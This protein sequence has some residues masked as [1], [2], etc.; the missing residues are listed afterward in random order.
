MKLIMSDISVGI[1]KRNIQ[2]YIYI[3]YIYCLY[4]LLIYI[5]YIY[6]IYYGLLIFWHRSR[7][8]R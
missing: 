2:L 6:K 4:I 5:V 1:I 8:R 3:A 7:I